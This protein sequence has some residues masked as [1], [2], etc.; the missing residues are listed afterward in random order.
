MHQPAHTHAAVD[1]RRFFGAMA[2]A[3]LVV[4]VAGFGWHYYLWP[5]TRATRHVAGRP[6]AGA[7]PLVVHIHAIAFSAWVVL[8]VVQGR[9]AARAPARHRALGRTGAWLVPIMLVT[10]LLAAVQGARDGWNPGGPYRDALA[11]M[12][13]GIADLI[14]FTTLTTAALVARRQPDLHMRLMLLGTLGGL[15]WPAITRIPL[16]AGRAP[17]MFGVL[18]ALVLAPAMRDVL[19]RAPRRWVSLGVGVAIL[20]TFPMRVAI[21]NGDAWRRL[22]MSML[23]G[24]VD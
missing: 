24:P 16:I 20:A 17:L 4:M 23:G 3:A 5:L 10:G 11:F 21:G 1:D 13:V 18:A 6:M 12:F 9:L 19:V 22:A 8:L 2:L 15:M 14:V 7:T